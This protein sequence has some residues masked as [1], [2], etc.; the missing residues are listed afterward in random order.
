[1]GM[2]VSMDE[3]SSDE[4]FSEINITPL[5]D[6]FL[7]LLIIFMVTSSVMSQMGVNVKLPEASSKVS[8]HA[9]EGVV[10]TLMANG[11]L[12]INETRILPGDWESLELLLSQALEQT[13]KKW[14]VL[15]GDRQA[16]LGE[17]VKV[18]ETA[19]KAGAVDFSIAT[20]P[21]N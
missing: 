14:V 18:M 13:Q 5:T 15:E 11:G 17:M 7:V 12:K 10:V 4:I 21:K 20:Q 8:E 6:I 16:V 9:P 3:D 2:K 1:M 19:K